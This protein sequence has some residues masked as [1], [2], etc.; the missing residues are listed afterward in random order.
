LA[1]TNEALEQ[2]VA[3]FSRRPV[4]D[5]VALG[6]LEI[7]KKVT[8]HILWLFAAANVV[9]LAGLAIIYYGDL[10]LLQVGKITP[11]ERIINSNVVMTLLGATTVQLGAD[12]KKAPQG[13]GRFMEQVQMTEEGV[14]SKHGGSR[15][16][17]GSIATSPCV[18]DLSNKICRAP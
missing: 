11:A 10:S 5:E 17:R 16:L 15:Y 9:V 7:R 4:D 2:E 12:P 1:T 3:S 8:T 18:S 14:S 6:D 13:R